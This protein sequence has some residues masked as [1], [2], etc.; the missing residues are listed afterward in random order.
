MYSHFISINKRQQML[1]TVQQNPSWQLSLAQ[2]SPSLFDFRS[3]TWHQILDTWYLTYHIC[4]L[5][6]IIWYFICFIFLKP[7]ITCKKIVSSRSCCTS[8][9]FRSVSSSRNR[10][11][12]KKKNEKVSNSN[13]LSLVGTVHMLCILTEGTVPMLFI[14]NVWTA[15]SSPP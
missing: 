3:E 13:K 10:L 7:M 11:I 1:I 6:L 4:F 14:S 2:L 5:I 15:Q 9:I 8:R 12:E